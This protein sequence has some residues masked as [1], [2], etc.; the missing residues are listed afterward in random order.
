MLISQPFLV[1]FLTNSLKIHENNLQLF[2]LLVIQVLTF[3][4]AICF[5]QKVKING[6]VFVEKILVFDERNST[7]C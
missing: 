7:Y 2:Q 1:V 3:K 6:Y 5:E 4:N